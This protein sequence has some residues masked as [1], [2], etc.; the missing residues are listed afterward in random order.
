MAPKTAAPKKSVAET[1]PEDE[2][3]V[4][5][6][7]IIVAA[8]AKSPSKVA[9]Y[10]EKAAPTLAT[11]IVLAQT[12]WPHVVKYVG[13]A[14]EMYEK[15][16]KAA[17]KIMLGFLMCFFG[18]IFPATI[19]AFEAFK[20]C[21]GHEA[22]KNVQELF[23]QMAGVKD[24]LAEDEAK[25]AKDGA[26]ASTDMDGQQLAAHKVGIAA[27]VLD[28]VKIN[29]NLGA[30]YVVWAGVVATLKLQFAR[31]VALS[32]GISDTLFDNVE[33]HALPRVKPMVPDE[34]QK[35]VPVVAS[36]V[37]KSIAVS[38]AWFIQSIISAVHGGIRG[39]F[40]M[41]RNAIKLGNQYGFCNIN[42]KETNLDEIGG[43]ILAF[44][45]FLF[46]LKSAFTLPF[47]LKLFFWP[48]LLVEYCIQWQVS[49]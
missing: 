23:A 11:L 4:E 12:A 30:L 48:V 24:A 39:G 22:I 9:P 29:G 14:S 33:K 13:I 15:L 28:P 47:L 10:I 27:R 20:L 45:G 3:K 41:S 19:A 17:L 32:V 46:Q 42:H 6:M 25:D 26:V 31:T 7:K 5:W 21:G 36:W 37:C 1:G 35:W 49:Y 43:Y 2:R 8:S 44:I 38:L 40:M 34:Y 18:G 16:P